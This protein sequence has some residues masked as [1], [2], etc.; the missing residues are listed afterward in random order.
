MARSRKDAW[1]RDELILALDL[2]RAE[3]RT[4]PRESVEQLS[5]LLRSIPIE[6]ELAAS[7]RF[8]NTAG[9]QLKIYNFVAIDPEGEIEGMSRGGRGDQ[10]VMDEFW[11]DQDRLRETAAAIRANLETIDPNE[12]AVVEEEVEDAPEGRILTRTHRVRERNRRLVERKKAAASSLACEACDFDFEAAYGKR[13][14]GF[15][16]CHHTVPVRDLVAVSRTRL[17]DLALVCANCHR[18]IHRGA[19]WLTVEEVRALVSA[20]RDLW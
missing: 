17:D 1:L 7:P 5:D 12:A 6:P 20:R 14:T 9:V 10:A 16:E 11:D 3:G 15:I 2:Y 4:P 8:R 19:P 18:M 13:G